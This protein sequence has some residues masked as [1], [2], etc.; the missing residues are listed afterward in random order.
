MHAGGTTYLDLTNYIIVN[1]S[2][3]YGNTVTNTT[4]FLNYPIT[5]GYV[6]P[7]TNFQVSFP[8]YNA[9]DYQYAGIELSDLTSGRSILASENTV[10]VTGNSS[11]THNL[12]L[13]SGHNYTIR[14][15]LRKGSVKLYGNLI[16]FSAVTK[17]VRSSVSSGSNG[18]ISSLIQV[19]PQAVS[20]MTNEEKAFYGI[21]DTNEE[22]IASS[23][24]P[25]AVARS[26]CTNIGLD[27]GLFNVGY[28][29]CV[30]FSFLFIPSESSIDQFSNLTTKMQT[31]AGFVYFAEGLDAYNE[32]FSYEALDTAEI[33]WTI[34][35]TTFEQSTGISF[36]PHR[37][38]MFSTTTVLGAMD[39]DAW[40][41]AQLLMIAATWFMVGG[42][43]IN[44]IRNQ[45]TS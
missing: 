2:P 33:V 22:T 5:N 36:I 17:T 9:S 3:D 8:Y 15:Y 31:K 16:T 26:Y 43:A 40:G 23:T 4:R 39:Q 19:T 21:D 34:P 24:S 1:S 11:T 13:V 35:T 30:A 42:F 37:I 29:I 7:S 14:P 12:N 38:V 20:S 44:T 28:G 6:T 25:V 18:F 10:L 41:I 45:K 27:P 32:A